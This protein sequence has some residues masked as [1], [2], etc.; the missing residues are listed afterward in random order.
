[1]TRPKSYKSRLRAFLE[2]FGVCFYTL[3]RALKPYLPLGLGG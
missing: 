2:A 1:M 3:D